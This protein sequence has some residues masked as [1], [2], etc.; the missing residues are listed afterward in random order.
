MCGKQ[1]KLKNSKRETMTA[2]LFT[3]PSFLGCAPSGAR[4]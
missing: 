2:Y 4:F 3:V 1:N